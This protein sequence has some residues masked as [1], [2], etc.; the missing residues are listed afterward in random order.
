MAHWSVEEQ[1]IPTAPLHIKSIN[2]RID[3]ASSHIMVMELAVDEDPPLMGYVLKFN[4]NGTF[5]EAVKV[6]DPN[7]VP[8]PEGGATSA[9]HASKTKK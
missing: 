4:K 8:P 5:I 7:Y 9:H 1:T 2:L 6:E 3:A